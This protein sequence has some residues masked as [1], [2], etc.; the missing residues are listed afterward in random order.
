MPTFGPKTINR[1]LRITALGLAVWS[2]SKTKAATD[3]AAL[4]AKAD[5]FF[6][7]FKK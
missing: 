7:Y 5:A 4:T 6:S 2:A 3:E 1:V